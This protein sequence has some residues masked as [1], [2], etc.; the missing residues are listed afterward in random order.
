MTVTA[1]RPGR[2]ADAARHQLMSPTPIPH[3]PLPRPAERFEDLILVS[4]RGPLTF[5]AEHGSGRAL[6]SGGGLVT[7]LVDL[8]RHSECT[9][10]ICAAVSDADR[11]AAAAGPVRLDGT[12]PC[13]VEML[14][15]GEAAH[16]GFYSIIANPILWFIQHYLW[17]LGRHPEFTASEHDAWEH[18][19]VAVNQQFA[20][21]TIAAAE[22]RSANAVVMVHD[23]HFYLVPSMVRARLP[24]AFIHFFVH[25]PWPQPDAW[26][27]LPPSMR[28]AVLE[29]VL[30]SDLVAF[31]TDRYARNFLLTCQELLD[32]DVDFSRFTVRH[33]GREVAVR[34]YPISVDESTLLELSHT[35][36][37]EAYAAEVGRASCGQLILR[38]DRTD[39]SKNIVRGFRA[40]DLL[41][42]KHP[43]L[44]GNVTFLAHLQP[45]RQDVQE[46]ADYLDAIIAIVDEVNTRHGAEGWRPIELRIEHNLPLAVAAYRR[47]DVLMV[48]SVF[49]GMNLVAKEAIVLTERD[50]VLA[51]SENTGAHEELGAV[52]I[53]LHPFDLEQQ[54][55][56]L[57]TALTMPADERRARHEAALDIVRTNNVTKWLVHQVTDVEALR[58]SR[59]VDITRE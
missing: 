37:V 32:L 50:G 3:E 39:P 25:I 4:H 51:L 7:A 9:H 29:G 35:P 28:D 5:D 23:Y 43:E 33:Q 19:Y 59:H 49:D 56:A 45:S 31:H 24:D 27:V 38:V 57:W 22:R 17:D 26:R 14:T 1:G 21:A 55:S 11:T 54:A 15:V 42:T 36:E 16:H 10:W 13:D 53:T 52:A 41:L 48:N 2:A 58:A 8:V 47:F 12:E 46:Y 44:H 18:G 30:G 6:R 20:D 40:Y 34:H